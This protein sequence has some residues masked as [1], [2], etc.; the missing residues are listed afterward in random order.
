[1]SRWWWLTL[2]GFIY[3]LIVQVFQLFILKQ[4]HYAQKKL[5]IFFSFLYV[6]V[7]EFPFMKL[8]H[9]IMQTKQDNV[10][11]L[12]ADYRLGLWLIF[13][14]GF[15]FLM[16]YEVNDT[17]Y[18]LLESCL[19]SFPLFCIFSFF[20]KNSQKNLIYNWCFIDFYVASSWTIFK[21][22]DKPWVMLQGGN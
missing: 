8:E 11:W 5:K 7:K 3:T 6:K 14:R 2:V 16:L 12:S 17:L 20:C 22:K 4:M 21:C 19:I 10:F 13:L 9:Y 1:M 15:I 18:N